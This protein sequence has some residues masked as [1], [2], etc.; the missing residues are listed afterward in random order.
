MHFILR[1]ILLALAVA[2]T[3]DLVS[4]I[5]VNGGWITLALVAII[6]GAIVSFIRP[7]LRILTLPITLVTFGLFSFV[8]NAILF[9]VVSLIVPGFSIGTVWGALVGAFVLSLCTW[10]IDSLV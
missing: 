2:L 8:L 9:Y 1:T 3:A 7:I 10:A 5:Y 6:W 4:G